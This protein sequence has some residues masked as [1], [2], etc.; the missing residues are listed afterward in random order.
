MDDELDALKKK[1]LE[2]LQRQLAYQQAMEQQEEEKEKIDEERK[3][4]LSLILTSEARSRLAR[5]RMARPEYAEAIEN[6]LIMLAQSGKIQQKITDQQ[7]K[8]LL[9]QLAQRK[10]DIRIRRSGL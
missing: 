1:K 3:K 7:L 2:E 4:L 9:A 10:K 6:Q 8:E 5:I